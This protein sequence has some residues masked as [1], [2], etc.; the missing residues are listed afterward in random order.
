[1]KTVFNVSVPY[2]NT[3]YN[4]YSTVYL[5]VVTVYDL[6]RQASIWSRILLHCGSSR[7]S[8]E[9]TQFPDCWVLGPFSLA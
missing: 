7:M 1:M 2:R 4:Y 3:T 8:L 6:I 5:F 9:F